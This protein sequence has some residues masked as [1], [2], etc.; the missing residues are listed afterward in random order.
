M[1]GV[2]GS[3]ELESPR[4][5]T[6]KRKGHQVHAGLSVT[7]GADAGLKQAKKKPPGKEIRRK[8]ICR[9]DCQGQQSANATKRHRTAKWGAASQM[10]PSSQSAAQPRQ[11]AVDSHGFTAEGTV[12]RSDAPFGQ[13]AVGEQA[14]AE[15][16]P[17]L[18]VTAS[19]SSRNGGSA[20]DWQC[21]NSR[22]H[23]A[24]RESSEFVW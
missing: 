1:P 24:R 9:G 23:T 13:C 10:Q 12:E 16:E 5:P 11:S 14:E 15:A 18:I 17:P 4:A 19:R 22:A 6:K 8:R 7:S 21:R 3:P 2:G 20:T